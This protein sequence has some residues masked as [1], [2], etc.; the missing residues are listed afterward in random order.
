MAAKH[1]PSPSLV[2]MSMPELEQLMVERGEKPYRGRQIAFWLYQRLARDASEMTDL[3]KALRTSLEMDHRLAALEV[4]SVRRAPDETQKVL[5]QLPDG[6]GVEGVLMRADHRWTMCLSSQVGCALRCQFCVTGTLGLRRNLTAGEMVDQ[7]LIGR[8][9]L[10]ETDP[11]ARLTN[12]VFMGM[13]EPLLNMDN[14]IRAI[15]IMTSPQCIAMS[16]RRITVSTAGVTPGVRRLGEEGLGVNLAL[17]V[18]A[19]SRELREMLMPHATRWPLGDLMEAMRAYPLANRQ[20]LTLEYVLLE[21]INDSPA[22][23]RRL[24][25]L[26]RGLRCKINLIPFNEASVLALRRPRP[27]VVEHFRDILRAE[28]LTASVRYSKGCSI[29]A[30]CG[31]LAAALTPQAA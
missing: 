14:L 9:L 6:H 12:L 18:N 25:K 23:A 7:V 2:G 17:S 28:N 8:R 30:A 27:A 24:A 31:Q 1:S 13:G 29:D 10:A 20:R 15:R 11:E 22:E 5:F 21:D 4:L 16:P 26:T 3:P 19:V